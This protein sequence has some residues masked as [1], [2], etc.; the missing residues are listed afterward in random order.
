MNKY[1][2]QSRENFLS[3]YVEIF[4]L[5]G[6]FLI[7]RECEYKY[8]ILLRFF[9]RDAMYSYNAYYFHKYFIPTYNNINLEI[10]NAY[11]TRSMKI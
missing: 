11:F 7:K 1:K 4:L 6:Y 9:L 5:K 10:N 8:E 3:I 2:E